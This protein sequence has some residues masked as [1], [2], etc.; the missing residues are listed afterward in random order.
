MSFLR[1]AGSKRQLGGILQNCWH[2]AQGAGGNG[3]Y[4]ETFCG[5]ASL[6][7]HIRPNDGILLDVNR[8]L[9]ECFE[10]VKNTPIKLATTLSE[11]ETGQDYYYSLRARDVTELTKVERAARFIYLNRFC[12]NGLYRTNQAGHF[13]VPYGA[14]RSGELPSL[15]LL[16]DCSRLL[17]NVELRCADFASIA[18][19]IIPGDF[20]YLDPPY[21]KRNHSLD[22][23]YGPDVFGVS[24]LSR[25]GE[26]LRMIDGRGAFF[27]FSY[28]LCDEIAAI[29]RDWTSF[30]VEVKRTIAANAS[31]RLKLT[32]VLISN[33]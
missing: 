22:L 32:E 14:G 3:R 8:A 28:V 26:M 30:P 9:V 10:V 17:K 33:I 13:N 19:E 21:A 20:V 24:D 5:S 23:Q 31:K 1:W 2:A 16:R 6:F 15:E 25:V 27:V 18:A 12:F 4:I 11:F 7:F 29:A